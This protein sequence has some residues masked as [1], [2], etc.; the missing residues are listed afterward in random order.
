MVPR[1]L[2]VTVLAMCVLS[3]AAQAAT[4]PV[5]PTATPTTGVVLVNTNLAL[6]G[7]TAAGTG[8]VLTKTGEVLTNNHVIAGATTITVTVPT[9]KKTYSASVLGYDVTDDVALIQLQGA[10]NLATATLG[11]S[12]KLK[13]GQ[14]TRAVGNAEGRGKLVQT[15][16]KILALNQTIQIRDDFGAVHTLTSLV[17]SSA[18]LVP[19]DS[20]G[21][22]L[23][24][25]NQVIG[26]DAAGS[27]D[28]EV[29]T[30]S[31]GYAIAIDKVRAIGNQ[32]KAQTA[33]ALVHIGETAF[34]GVDTQDTQAGV[35]IAD[36]VAG[37][38]AEQLGLQ[39]GD[40][41]TS[42]DGAPIS[43]TDD[44]RTVLFSHHPGDTVAL[45]YTDTNGVAQT[46]SITLASGPPQ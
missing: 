16:G 1:K 18:H 39:Q 29:N 23:N 41:L 38:P 11:K 14:A 27:S 30:S 31:P 40:V 32:I 6:Q 33:S 2:L 13:I 37:S 3:G 10:T 44:L 42:L 20:G 43:T 35:T 4:K 12:A 9:S 15:T 5:K 8:I 45:G 21:P 46:A 36:I 34:I 19:G 17:K 7:A 22:L 24:A 28:S 25:S 26:M